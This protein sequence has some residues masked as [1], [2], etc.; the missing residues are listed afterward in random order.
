MFISKNIPL[1]DLI[2]PNHVTY[3]I[4]FLN[5]SCKLSIDS[6]VNNINHIFSKGE[7]N[8]THHRSYNIL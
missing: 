3:V 1:G 6:Y 4:T 2:R 7:K 8:K 5:A